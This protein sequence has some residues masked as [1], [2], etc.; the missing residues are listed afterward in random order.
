MGS[1]KKV[2][3][4]NIRTTDPD[5]DHVKNE[6]LTAFG[7]SLARVEMSWSEGKPIAAA[8][9]TAA[10]GDAAKSASAPKTAVSPAAA[11]MS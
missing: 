10:D 3:R 8:P 6:I 11:N 9:A 2:A 5:L 4:F 1:D 7:P